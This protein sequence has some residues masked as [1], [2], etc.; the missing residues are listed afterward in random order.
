MAVVDEQ[1]T[2]IGSLVNCRA[3]FAPLKPYDYALN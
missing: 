2:A 3:P 1:F